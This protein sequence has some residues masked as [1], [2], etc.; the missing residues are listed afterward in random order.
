ML[1]F[2]LKIETVLENKKL[3]LKSWAAW[4][5]KRQLSTLQPYC[6][7]NTQLDH[8]STVLYCYFESNVSSNNVTSSNIS[9]IR[10]RIDK[11]L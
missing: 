9:S 7:E 4:R 8:L 1:D 3:V 6:F 5:A 11:F 2:C 10:I